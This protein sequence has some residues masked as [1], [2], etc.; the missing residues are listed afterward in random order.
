MIKKKTFLIIVL[1]SFLISSFTFV[2]ASE[3][4]DLSPIKYID[5]DRKGNKV[6]INVTMPREVPGL[7]TKYYN[8]KAQISITPEHTDC[9]YLACESEIEIKNENN[10]PI[11]IESQNLKV[12][13]NTKSHE[14]IAKDISWLR[15]IPNILFDKLGEGYIDGTKFIDWSSNKNIN[16]EFDIT[17]PA[18]GSQKF[19]L[20]TIMEEPEKTYKYNISLWYGGQEYKI[21][22]TF[23]TNNSSFDDGTY[24]QTQLNESGYVEINTTSYFDGWYASKIFNVGAE[25]EWHNISWYTDAWGE[26]QIDTGDSWLDTTELYLYLRFNND[27]D[28]NE[29]ESSYYDYSENGHNWTC[30][31]CPSYT[32]GIQNNASTFP[33]SPELYLSSTGSGKFYDTTSNRT[34][35]T[36]FKI[37]TP[38]SSPNVLYEEGA[39]NN[40]HGIQYRKNADKMTYA[41]KVAGAGTEIQSVTTIGDNSDWHH[42]AVIWNNTHMLMYIDGKLDQTGTMASSATLPFASDDPGIGGIQGTCGGGI[43]TEQWDGDIDEFYAFDRVLSPTEIE[44]L[45][46][47]GVTKFNMNV[48]TC[49]DAACDGESY[50]DIDDYSP[51]QLSLTNNT[52]FQY[53]FSMI[54]NFSTTT[55]KFYNSSLDYTLTAGADS[56]A[57][58]IYLEAPVNNTINTTNATPT[59]WFNTTDETA[60]NLDC[61]LWLDNGTVTTYGNNASVNSGESSSFIT[62]NITLS[63]DDYWWWMNCSDGTNTNI[64]E[65]YNISIN[66]PAPDSNPPQVTIV[67]PLNQNYS[68]NSIDFNVT[69]DEASRCNVSIDNFVTNTTMTAHT[70]TNHGFTNIS[71]SD[72]DYTGYYGCE[73]TSGNMNKSESVSFSVDTTAPIISNFQFLAINSSRHQVGTDETA[74]NSTNLQAIEYMNITF[75][76]TDDTGI[77]G[78]VALWFTANGTNGCSRGNK[79][80]SQCYNL[81]NGI[82]VEFQNGTTTST[83]QDIGNQGDR[84][85]CSYNGNTTV[86]DYSCEVD[87]HYNPNVFK[88]YPFDFSDVKW[89][90]APSFRIKQGTLWRINVSGRNIPVNAKDYKLDFRVNHTNTP[91]QG[92][93][94]YLCN[95]TY[96]TGKPALSSN[97]FLLDNKLESAFQDDGTKYRSIFTNETIV[98]IG[99]PYYVVIRSSAGG[100]RYYQMK[101]YDYTG[102]EPIISEISTNTGNTWNVLADGYETELNINWFYQQSINQNRTSIPFKVF[103][104]DTLGNNANS[105]I[106]EVSWIMGDDNL[107]PVVVLTSPIVNSNHSGNLNISWINTDPNSNTLL[108]N[109]T[110]SNNSDSYL[111]AGN[112]GNDNTSYIF[113]TNTYSD[114]YWNVTVETCENTTVDLFCANDTHQILVDNTIPIITI[115]TPTNNT[116]TS[117]TGLNINYT[118]TDTNGIDTCWYSNDSYLENIT[119]ASCTNITSVTWSEGDHEVTVYAND[120]FGNE[121]QA[122]VNFTIDTTA[123]TITF[124]DETTN[125][126]T[127]SQDWII[128]KVSA[129]DASLDTIT[130]TL[131]NSDL[132]VNNTTSSATSPLEYNITNLDDGT[133]YLNA[134]VNDTTGNTADTETRTI[135]LD[136]TAPTITIT[137]PT[138]NTITSNTGLNVNYTATDTNLESCWYSNDS[139]LENITLASCTNIT[140]VTW[141]E[142]DHNVTVWV[143]D[144]AGNE[145]QASVN[146]TIDTITPLVSWNTPTTQ[147]NYS[148][149]PVRFNFT[150]TE[151]NQESIIF[152]FDNGTGTD[153][154]ITGTAD[155][156][157]Y[158]TDQDITNFQ[159]GSHTIIAWVNDSVNNI[160]DSES[161]TIRYDISSPSVTWNTPANNSN[162]SSGTVNFNSTVIDSLLDVSTVIFQ[163]D[164]SSG[165]DFNITP[166]N[167]NNEWNYTLNIANLQEGTHTVTIYTNDSVDNINQTEQLTFTVDT[168]AP[169]VT[170]LIPSVNSVFNITNVIEIAADVTDNLS[171]SQ[172]FANVSYPN[173]TLKQYTLTLFTGDKYNTSFIIPSLLGTYNITYW[174]NDT[175]NNINSS[176]TSNFTVNDVA[177]PLVTWTGP[178]NGTSYSSGIVNLNATV[179]DDISVSSVIFMFDNSSGTAFNITPDNTGNIYNYSLNVSDVGEG[180]HIVTI[181]TN[182]SSNNINQTEQI[183]FIYS[184]AAETPTETPTGGDSYA[185]LVKELEDEIEK[186]IRK[187]KL[188][189]ERLHK[190]SDYISSILIVGLLLFVFKR[191]KK[192]K[193][194]DDDEDD[195]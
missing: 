78:D 182:D 26:A 171:A 85:T 159:E 12:E 89:Q 54:T 180:A 110:Y 170:S 22:P 177:A 106:Y 112:F 189:Q 135:V 157:N 71:M 33:Q 160:N 70:T 17:I 19:L 129:T 42:I 141:S 97:C 147:T 21:D 96:T 176:E 56:E 152:Q 165:T 86:R 105:S 137:T 188:L 74:F 50:T 134:T 9:S 119:L 128:A 87:E 7:K 45:Y 23:T 163:F 80:S 69:L 27:S 158:Y 84:I 25:A 72:G 164:N 34:I 65:K 11:T 52:Y 175:L 64:S 79:Q 148:S 138:N 162:Y 178:V 169:N 126:S 20:K 48:R 144:T 136:S 61:N 150:I 191:N 77:E 111:I 145:N 99:T 76:V 133:Y 39:T 44:E 184:T 81:D 118:A 13:I 113:N 82:W 18:F 195:N 49:N 132:S 29:S 167:V 95:E 8:D 117:N 1:V 123:P 181:L 151:T 43:G 98:G 28:Y 131:Y 93:E 125:S 83:F 38:V 68:T 92:L 193:D 192:K 63:N 149:G 100:G 41:V 36:W 15:E 120:T 156:S 174:A 166:D 59:F 140:S 30:T 57:P 173:G 35:A 3:R 6:F 114:G 24:F 4:L 40:G 172:V 101:T 103:A 179:T 130:L 122:T 62:S 94:T 139:Y 161:I 73:D 53:N 10:Y 46:E 31:T 66:I 58:E 37:G 124:I 16:E 168:T 2:I 47:R 107:P 190:Y 142:G 121:N 183:S 51:V 143:N 127:L 109:I 115:T 102:S 55:P 67:N 91:I 194:E 75:T 153:F 154:N 187:D 116:V 90:T 104:N 5:L 108:T 146:F 185:E 60:S 186:F 14:I 32:K 155:G 88:H